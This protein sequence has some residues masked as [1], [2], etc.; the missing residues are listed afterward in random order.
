MLL[1]VGSLSQMTPIT[2]GGRGIIT[3]PKL[4]LFER[5]GGPEGCWLPKFMSTIEKRHLKEIEYTFFKQNFSSTFSPFVPIYFI[6]E[7]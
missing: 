2:T 4:T 5:G 6:I 7:Y 1:T 3:L